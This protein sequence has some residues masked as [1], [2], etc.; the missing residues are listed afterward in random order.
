MKRENKKGKKSKLHS[1]VLFI[2]LPL[3]ILSIPVALYVL[4]I[5]SFL[6]P[7]VN[8]LHSAKI[9]FAFD[10]GFQSSLIEAAPTL[11]KYEFP[12]VVYV[13]T[14]CIDNTGECR[15]RFPSGKRFLTWDELKELNQT[16]KWEIGD[17]TQNH[18]PL[19]ELTKEQ[20]EE[21]IGGSKK[22]LLDQGFYPVS[23]A[24]PQGDYDPETLVIVMKHY[25][26]HRGFKDKGTNDW[27]YDSALLSVKQVQEGTSVDEV[28]KTIDTAIELQQ[29]LILVFHDIKDT[30]SSAPEEYE[31]ATSKLDEIAKYV[32]EKQEKGQIKTVTVKD[33]VLDKPENLVSNHTFERSDGDAWVA[34][35]SELVTIDHENNGSYPSPQD[36]A[37]MIGSPNVANFHTSL[38][39]VEQGATYEFRVFTNT[40][41]QKSGE[42]S[43]VIDEHTASGEWIRANWLGRVQPQ[44]ISYLT[45][46][47]SPKSSV[48]KSIRIQANL[49]KNSEGTVFIDS[50]QFYKVD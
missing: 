43:F 49:A 6:S 8:E 9:T 35:S 4:K 1:R 44:N 27:L 11:A 15:N 22:K 38:I 30:P 28:K 34:N 47:Y 19:T 18:Y 29:W 12:A 45:A 21:E 26:S 10:D 50:F 5:Q 33:I 24:S 31:Y 14:G 42:L 36:S 23:F 3:I 41:H 39:P 37:K 2:L 20:K 48:V 13:S 32:K 16:Y 7:P 46:S 40:N 17:H 25:A